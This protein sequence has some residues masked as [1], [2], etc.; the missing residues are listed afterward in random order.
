MERV[1]VETIIKELARYR[2]IDP[3]I[4]KAIKL[5]EELRTNYKY[6]KRSKSQNGYLWELIGKLADTLRIGKDEL[7]IHLLEEY[8]QGDY[9][10]IKSNVNPRNYFK[11]Y[12][13]VGK[14]ND[15]TFYKV[16]RGS[17]E[18]DSKEMSI[19]IDGLI[20]ECKEQNIETLTPEEIAKMKIN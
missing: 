12:K 6:K 7:Y 3:V 13:E 20:Q 11:Y 19:L 5:I 8:G 15:C 17:S 1:E 14:D 9:I 4:E 18:Y 16:Y 2:H 10:K